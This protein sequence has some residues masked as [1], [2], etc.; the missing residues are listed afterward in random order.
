MTQD[1]N[2]KIINASYI[3]KFG[4]GGCGEIIELKIF[5]QRFTLSVDVKCWSYNVKQKYTGYVTKP[6]NNMLMLYTEELY[7][8]NTGITKSC[9][10]KQSSEQHSKITFK[11]IDLGSRLE[12]TYGDHVHT[13][14][15]MGNTPV[16]NYSADPT[17]NCKY[18]NLLIAYLDHD[19]KDPKSN[20]KIYFESILTNTLTLLKE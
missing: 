20:N 11:L 16:F 15:V 9:I 7:D 6:A 14:L 4:C 8:E 13:G 10:V 2:H 19:L 1:N 5:D 18:D 17:K 12:P 3:Y